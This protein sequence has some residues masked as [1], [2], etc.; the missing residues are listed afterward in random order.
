MRPWLASGAVSVLSIL[1][2]AFTGSTDP[3]PYDRWPPQQHHAHVHGPHAKPAPGKHRAY[4]GGSSWVKEKPGP[5]PS[6]KYHRHLSQQK[7][8]QYQQQHHHRQQ[9]QNQQH[10]QR[11]QQ[12]PHHDWHAHM[13]VDAGQ[14]TSFRSMHG[15]FTNIRA[16][17][18]PPAVGTRFLVAKNETA[19]GGNEVNKSLP[20]GG[21]GTTGVGDAASSTSDANS[22]DSF[23]ESAFT[24]KFAK[25]GPT[26]MASS[27]NHSL[28]HKNQTA[29]A[30]ASYYRAG[31]TSTATGRQ[32]MHHAASADH[33][34]VWNRTSSHSNSSSNGTRTSSSKSS[35]SGSNYTH[36]HHAN[37][38][39]HLSTSGPPKLSAASNREKTVD[40][41]QGNRIR[42]DEPVTATTD[43]PS[44]L[45]PAPPPKQLLTGTRKVD[46][47]S[48]TG[49][50]IGNV[51]YD[52]HLALRAWN[53]A[54]IATWI[55]WLG[56]ALL[57]YR[58]GYRR[59]TPGTLDGSIKDKGDSWLYSTTSSPSGESSTG[60][61]SGEAALKVEE[62]PQFIFKHGHFSCAADPQVAFWAFVCP[63]IRWAE[64]VGLG[65]IT[66]FWVAFGCYSLLSLLNYMNFYSFGVAALGSIIC[67]GYLYARAVGKLVPLNHE[68]P[69]A[70]MIVRMVVVSVALIY[71]LMAVLSLGSAIYSLM[72]APGLSEYMGWEG[73]FTWGVFTTA[74]MLYC[75]QRIRAMLG[76]EHYDLPTIAGDWCFLFW[77]PWCAVAQEAR[78]VNAAYRTSHP[79]VKGG[80][81]DDLP[82]CA[83]SFME[84][85][86]WNA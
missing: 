52:G 22:E 13:L 4:G 41:D 34:H 65:G 19:R 80:P 16:G 25:A 67:S 58:F 48:V 77:C 70:N 12:S 61:G 39:A 74:A 43:S 36:H 57:V 64:T 69:Q 82:S 71:Y 21:I 75:R 55:L 15:N 20:D 79:S 84:T 9:H 51:S 76:L 18:R 78:V 45:D 5:V 49:S 23:N 66:H 31:N 59:S 63:G 56:V 54:A 7:Q 60:A 14:A 27:G 81:A 86:G 46:A 85:Q 17:P 72:S 73:C 30:A 40:H 26:T 83:S 50:R 53:P 24:D 28:E 10:P 6:N 1:S 29:N 42:S 8:T 62:D 2:Q 11:H 68:D 33:E 47:A 44:P 38:G 3:A 37:R 32:A 35:T